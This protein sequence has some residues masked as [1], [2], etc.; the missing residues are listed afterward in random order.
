MKALI[1]ISYPMQLTAQRTPRS[2]SRMD[3]K[4]FRSLSPLIT[5]LGQHYYGARDSQVSFFA[6]PGEDDST[7]NVDRIETVVKELANSA[8]RKYLTNSYDKNPKFK[9]EMAS[10]RVLARNQLT[11]ATAGLLPY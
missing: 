11:D 3:H 6:A 9:Q 7:V 10:W 2:D 5:L 8:P 1:Q 4:V